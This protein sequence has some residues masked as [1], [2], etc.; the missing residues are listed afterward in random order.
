MPTLCKF[1]RKK[2]WKF[3][4][5]LQKKE[6]Q[7]QIQELLFYQEKGID[8]SEE[9]A[10]A[11]EKL[12]LVE[13]ELTREAEVLRTAKKDL[14]DIEKFNPTTVVCYQN[15]NVVYECKKSSIN[16]VHIYQD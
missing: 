15:D 12:K 10:V 1:S 4:E 11:Q 16:C 6:L 14:A 9:L 5:R 7:A 3:E 13:F 2:F 8:V